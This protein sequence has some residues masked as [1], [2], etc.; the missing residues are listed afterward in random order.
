MVLGFGRP[1]LLLAAWGALWGLI[2]AK[3]PINARFGEDVTLSCPFP[4]QPGLKLQYL[5]V[6]WQKEQVGAEDLVVHSYYYGK[7]QLV[8][9]D[10]VYRNRTWLDPEGLARGNASLTLRGVRTQDEG[11][12]R[13]YVHSELDGTLQTIQLTVTQTSH[14]LNK[15]AGTAGNAA[16]LGGNWVPLLSLWLVLIIPVLR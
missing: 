4:S 14:I 7:D 13:C 3:S 8:R 1:L 6:S 12:Y 11:V 10:K 5:T 9:Q 2:A 15:L 16:G